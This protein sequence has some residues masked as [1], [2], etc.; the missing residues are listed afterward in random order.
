MK[1]IAAK[2]ARNRF[3]RLRIEVGLGLEQLDRDEATVLDKVGLED[4][5]DDIQ[6]K[7]RARRNAMD[8]EHKST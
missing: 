2:K 3:E 7:G 1:A 5:F 4:L 8:V 6:A